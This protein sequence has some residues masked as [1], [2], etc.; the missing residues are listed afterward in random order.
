MLY[1]ISQPELFPYLEDYMGQRGKEK[2]NLAI[3]PPLYLSNS[4]Y[5][6]L[7]TLTGAKLSAF[8]NPALKLL[9]Q[10]GRNFRARCGINA[11]CVLPWH[12]DFLSDLS[13]SGP[14]MSL[15]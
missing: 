2:G 15:D 11:S 13:C 3:T 5:I 4:M 14:L 10:A 8:Q 9:I 1:P 12:W 7:P 6:Y